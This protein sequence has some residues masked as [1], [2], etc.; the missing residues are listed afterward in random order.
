MP[1]PGEASVLINYVMVTMLWYE[2][3]YHLLYPE[4]YSLKI[5]DICNSKPRITVQFQYVTKENIHKHKWAEAGSRT[6]SVA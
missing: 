5:A 4:N 3:K 2:Q 6:W 1:V